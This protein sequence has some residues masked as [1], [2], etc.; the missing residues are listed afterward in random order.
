MNDP[1]D[2][3]AVYR[4]LKRRKTIMQTSA[5]QAGSRPMQCMEIWGSS[6][7]AD[8]GI[9]TPGLD[10]WVL[11]KPYQG[12]A[13]GGDV[14]YVSLCGGGITTRVIV[15][16]VAG[17]GGTVLYRGGRPANDDVTVLT[18]HHTASKSPRLSFGQMLDVYAKVLHLKRV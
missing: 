11:G 2:A 6:G 18:M 9:S 15:A 13:K 7:A 14:H 10:I 1:V 8:S 17:H 12:A 5:Q 3:K 16:D 4:T